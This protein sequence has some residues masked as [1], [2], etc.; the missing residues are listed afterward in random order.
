MYGRRGVAASGGPRLLEEL[1]PAL[2]PLPAPDAEE[3]DDRRDADE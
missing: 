2:F 1:A 3:G